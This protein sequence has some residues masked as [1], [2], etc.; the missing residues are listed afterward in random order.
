MGRAAFKKNMA[1]IDKSFISLMAHKF[2]MA[3][4]TYAII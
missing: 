4:R 2:I 1:I 3:K